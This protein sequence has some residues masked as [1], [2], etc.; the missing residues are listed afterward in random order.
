MGKGKKRIFWINGKAGSGKSTLM[1]YIT[2]NPLAL[3]ILKVWQTWRKLIFAGFFFHNRGNMMQKSQVGL[4]R[5]IL[6]QVLSEAQELIPVVWAT[7][8]NRE[9]IKNVQL[10]D[11]EPVLINWTAFKLRRAFKALM[12][13]Q[14]VGLDI[15]L[16]IDGL[17]EYESEEGQEDSYDELLSFIK[18]ITSTES[19]W[20]KVKACVS[21]R[22]L[23]VFKDA[24]SDGPGLR[25]QDLTRDDINM[26]LEDHLGGS[27]RPMQ[28]LNQAGKGSDYII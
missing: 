25:L 19:Q 28:M 3:D 24:F 20:I 22:P 2:D 8:G 7:L 10:D 23:N 18:E 21:S 6:Y 5:S 4:L 16:M 11:E 1:K 26:Y 9:Y 14:I 27:Q 12:Q 15:C 13:Q 17:D